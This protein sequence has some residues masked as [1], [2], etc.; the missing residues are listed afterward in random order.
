M[1]KPKVSA[2]V[3]AAEAAEDAKRAA[4]VAAKEAAKQAEAAYSE[5]RAVTRTARVRAD[6]GLPRCDMVTRKWRDPIADR[7]PVAILRKTP[8]GMLVVRR[9]GSL[10]ELRFKFSKFRGA[11][12]EAVKA[13]SFR[14]SRALENVPPEWMPSHPSPAPDQGEGR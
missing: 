9:P 14:D 4:W 7:S 8:G 1:A 3:A 6:D 12:V 5:A 13:G 10:D 2:E 11:Y